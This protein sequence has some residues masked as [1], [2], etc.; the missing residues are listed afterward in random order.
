MKSVK[1]AEKLELSER[2]TMSCEKSSIS[3]E[4]VNFSEKM[5][6]IPANVE[7]METE[8]ELMDEMLCLENAAEINRSCDQ[9]AAFISDL[10]AI[11]ST[12]Q[13]I[14]AHKIDLRKRLMCPVVPNAIPVKYEQQAKF[15]AICEKLPSVVD[16]LGSIQS[17]E[18]AYDILRSPQIFS[19]MEKEF[20][21]ARE[22]CD[23]IK[24]FLSSSEE[25]LKIVNVAG[26]F[27]HHSA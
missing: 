6:L 15:V 14:I 27:L 16:F 8:L 23:Q 17:Q 9:M 19:H 5:K 26:T 20:K 18:Q 2:I 13:F 25:F 21:S 7:L 10:E 12:F 22:Y 11:S 24:Y 3:R 1:M 4:S